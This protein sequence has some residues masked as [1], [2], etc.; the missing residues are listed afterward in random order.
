MDP[1]VDEWL[2]IHTYMYNGYYPIIIVVQNEY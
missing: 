1:M 2:I